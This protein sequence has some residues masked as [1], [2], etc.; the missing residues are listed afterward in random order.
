MCCFSL[1]GQIT[2]GV[3]ILVAFGFTIG[4]MLSPGKLFRSMTNNGFC[5]T[6]TYLNVLPKWEKAVVATMVLGVL[7]EVAAFVWDLL[8]L[9]ACCCKQFILYPL[10]LLAMLG[11]IFLAIAVI[12]YVYMSKYLSKKC[13]LMIT[14]AET[15]DRYILINS[16]KNVGYSYYLACVALVLNL[17]NIIIGS[18]T[19]TLAKHCL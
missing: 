3:V 5:K 11:S 18:L 6:H 4:A 14:S 10:P 17:A 1:L 12:V 9:C 2:Y 16:I 15:T 8:T 7:A 13:K 19:V